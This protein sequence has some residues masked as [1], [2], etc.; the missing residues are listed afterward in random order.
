MRFIFPYGS[1]VY[2][3][4]HAQSDQ[5]FIIITDEEISAADLENVNNTFYTPD[6][7][8][9]MIQEHHVSSL[10]C[11]FSIENPFL[12]HFHLNRSKLRHAFSQK[13]SNSYVK[14]KKKLTVEVDQ[15]YI[16]RKSLWHSLRI[17]DYGTQ[18][19]TQSKIVDFC[20]VNNLYHDIVNTNKSWPEL[21]KTYKPVYNSFSSK[22]KAVAEK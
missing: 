14:A 15:E 5:D 13:A 16:G 18:I 11:I 12:Q 22:F 4:N 3:T 19:A 8:I 17:L 9:S 1:V 10:E 21:E 20:S 2:K 7:F 6:A